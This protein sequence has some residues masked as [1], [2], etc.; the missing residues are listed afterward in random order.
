MLCSVIA[1]DRLDLVRPVPWAK[2]S[3]AGTSATNARFNCEPAVKPEAAGPDRVSR[4]VESK[5]REARQAGYAEGES[6]GRRIALEE[7]RPV[8]ERLGNTI[9]ELA[10]S[11]S[12]YLK[13]A[14][15]DVVRL[16]LA[17]ARRVLYRELTI[18]PSATAGLVKAALEKLQS[19][20]TTKIRVHPDLESAVRGAIERSG[21]HA[22]A[23]VLPDSSLERGSVVFET[24]R[25]NLDA[26]IETQLKEIELGFADRF[27][28]P[29]RNAAA[30]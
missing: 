26:S 21:Q 2:T 23:E 10:E 9:T 22:L 29:Y 20:V 28:R 16:S 8:L 24:T 30:V 4:D 27:R 12:R 13:E 7:L 17:V 6:A 19:E 1:E 15:A 14:E 3:S 5:V 18:D 25:G 11:R